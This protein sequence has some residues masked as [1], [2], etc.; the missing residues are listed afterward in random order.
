MASGIS[1][2]MLSNREQLDFSVFSTLSSLA[3]ALNVPIS[4]LFR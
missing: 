4:A 2:G 3:K 1:T